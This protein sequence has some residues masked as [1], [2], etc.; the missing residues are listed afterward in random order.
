MASSR[1]SHEVGEPSDS[2]N[3]EHVPAVNNNF[4]CNICF[5]PKAAYQWFDIKNCSHGYCTECMVN[6]VASNLQEN[7][8][9]IRCPD[10]DCALGSIEPED[11]DWILP[12]EVFERWE[13]ALCEAAI[14]SSQKFYCPF[15]DCSAMLIIDDDGSEVVRQSQCPHCRRLFCAKCKV[16]WH[17]EMECWEFQELNDD[18]RGREDIQLKNLANMEDWKRCPNCKFYVE[19]NTGCNFMK[20]RCRAIFCYRCGQSLSVP[21]NQRNYCSYCTG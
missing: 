18:E 1:V 20:C 6:Y 15:R 13:S 3:I 17:A 9:T 7:V 12:Q 4:V 11:C 16:A 10:P 8:T 21:E 2:K 19:K 14:P 5:E